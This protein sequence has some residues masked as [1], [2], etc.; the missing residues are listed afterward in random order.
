MLVGDG[1]PNQIV[2]A[3]YSVYRNN[4]IVIKS[5]SKESDWKPINCGVRQECPL[6]PLLFNIHINAII[7][8]WRRTIYHCKMIPYFT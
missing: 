2:T 1:I 8:H 5:K 3:I 7:R 6:S 4:V